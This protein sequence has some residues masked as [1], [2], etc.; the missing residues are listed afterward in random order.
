MFAGEWC[1]TVINSFT[2]SPAKKEILEEQQNEMDMYSR[3]SFAVV[4]NPLFAD[5]E[6]GDDTSYAGGAD[7]FEYDSA[8]LDKKEDLVRTCMCVCVCA[9]ARVCVCIYVHVYVC[10]CVL[11]VA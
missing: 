6:E 8:T 7:G 3:H 9:C 10:T 1:T 11:I 2:C 4:E 5:T